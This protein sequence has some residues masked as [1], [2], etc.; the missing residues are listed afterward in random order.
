M[1]SPYARSW[2]P[3]APCALDRWLGAGAWRLERH[4]IR[5]AATAA[6]A[7]AALDGVTLRDLPAVRALF[8]L[9]GIPFSP[10]MTLRE[11]FGTPPF[12]VLEGDPSREWVFGV[13]GPFSR[14]AGARPPPASPAELAQAAR[15]SGMAAVGNFRAEPAEGGSR[16]WTE[17][18][19]LVPTAAGRLAFGAYWLAVGPFSAWIRRL[20]LRAARGRAV[21]SA[22]GS[23]RSP[24]RGRRR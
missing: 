17:T 20:L 12:F 21:P 16:L 23:R 1:L 22:S 5:V 9:R 15:R 2:P 8:A 14:D 18:W 13:V 6:S 10:A 19:V 4:E 11:F 3:R 7:L 24:D